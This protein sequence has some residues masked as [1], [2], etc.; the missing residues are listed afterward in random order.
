M[1]PHI[2][3]D[4]ERCGKR[5]H[6]FGE[7]VGDLM[8][9]CEPRPWCEKV[10]AITHKA[11]G[12]DAQFILDRAIFLKWNPKLILN[13]LEIIC[14]TI[15]HLT[16]IDSISF[17]PMALRKL[18]E[19]SGLSVTKSWYPHFFNTKANLNYVGP[20]PDKSIRRR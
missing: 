16:F 10:V 13:G 17:L 14:M 8:Y 1:Q 4:C 12:F 18:P 11:K 19:A 7:P 15:Q 9:L 6:C 5:K 20:I 2:H 3:V